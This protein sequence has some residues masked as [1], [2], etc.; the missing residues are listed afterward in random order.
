MWNPST[1]KCDSI[2]NLSLTVNALTSRVW[3]C[4]NTTLTTYG[5][6]FNADESPLYSWQYEIL[7]GGATKDRW[8]SDIDSIISSANANRLT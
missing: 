2:R 5:D 6:G 8:L 3:R 1:K 7:S 4:R